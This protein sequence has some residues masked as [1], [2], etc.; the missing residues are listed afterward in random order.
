MTTVLFVHGTGV[1]KVDY[2]HSFEEVQKG[3][4]G[5]AN[6]RIERCYWGDQGAKLHLNGVSIPEYV[7]SHRAIDELSEDELEL[8]L[9]H[10]LYRDPLY[11]LRLL[12]LQAGA[13][14]EFVPGQQSVGE[15]FN[16]RVQGLFL[17]PELEMKLK[18]ASLEPHTFVEKRQAVTNSEPYQAMLD[19]MSEETTAHRTAVARAIFAQMVTKSNANRDDVVIVSANLKKEIV[20]L[21]VD[22]LGGTD[23]AISDYLLNPLKGAALGATWLARKKRTPI[24][25]YAYPFAGDILCY[26]GRQGQLIRDYI[27]QRLKEI[28]SPVVILAHSLGGIMCVDVL[29][30]NDFSAQVKQ[31]ITVGSQAPL[32]YEIDALCKL[33]FGEDLPAHFPPWLNIYDVRDLLSFT[34]E[35]VFPG[36]IRDVVVNNGEPF[37]ESHSAYWKNPS[38]WDAIIGVL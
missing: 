5:L 7:S 12:S 23:R 38:V 34:G 8:V 17:T 32:L 37:K 4:V 36:K 28:V 16:E 3:L 11:E 27:T 33:P 25:D 24:M 29:V 26:Q 19:S 21:L 22:E 18:E 2:D 31:L 35:K 20:Q 14:E 6:I 10:E 15:Q 1:R 9:W 13:Q 30:E